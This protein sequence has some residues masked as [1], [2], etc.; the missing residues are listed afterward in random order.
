MHQQ[1]WNGVMR[2]SVL[3]SKISLFLGKRRSKLWFLQLPLIRRT[4][5]GTAA[6]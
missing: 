3:K 6:F 4:I 2:L 1:R 5:S